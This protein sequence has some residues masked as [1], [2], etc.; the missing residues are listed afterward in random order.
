MKIGD[1]VRYTGT[2]DGEFLGILTK[3]PRTQPNYPQTTEYYVI[4]TDI[5]NEGWW[6]KEVLEKAKSKNV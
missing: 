3:G 1:L 2:R 5:N 6:D 4:W